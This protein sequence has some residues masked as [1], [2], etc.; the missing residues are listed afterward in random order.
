M[1]V[2]LNILIGLVPI[3]LLCYFVYLRDSARPEKPKHLIFTFLLGIAFAYVAFFLESRID[4][5]GYQNSTEFIPY[6]L[7]MFLGVALIEEF[8]KLLPVMIFPFQKSFFD[9]PLDGIVYCVFA[10]MGFATFETVYYAQFLDWQGVLAKATLTV[11]AHAAFAMIT[12]YYLGR[13]RMQTSRAVRNQFILAGLGWAVLAHGL[14]DW[15]IFNPY[16][17]WLMLLA[18]VVLIVCWAVALRLTAKHA[19]GPEPTPLA[20]KLR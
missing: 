17:E 2:A 12:G 8:M 9:E 10:A 19:A 4:E 7:Y 16:E 20:S 14:Y 6:T 5:L 1:Q 3:V 11:P 18:V 13:A 15:M